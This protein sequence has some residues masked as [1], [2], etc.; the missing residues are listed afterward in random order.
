MATFWMQSWMEPTFVDEARVWIDGTLVRD[1]S[2]AGIRDYA[3][4]GGFLPGSKHVV[5]VEIRSKG[6]M[7]GARSNVWLAFWP[8][9]KSILDLSGEWQPSQDMLNY[10][11]AIP[12]PG[13]YKAFGLRRSVYIPEERKGDEVYVDGVMSGRLIGVL[14]NGHWVRRFHHDVDPH[15]HLNI[16]PWVKFGEENELQLVSVWSGEAEGKVESIRLEFHD[17]DAESVSNP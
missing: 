15:M 3:P 2:E 11:A 7:A 1:W 6:S 16:T 12:L 14:I 13:P 4:S 5:T 8:R 17:K 9:A 10:E